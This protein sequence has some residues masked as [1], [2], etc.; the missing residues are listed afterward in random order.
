MFYNFFVNKNYT[1]NNMKKIFLGL[2]SNIGNKEK[3]IK[4]AIKLLSDFV[5]K[6]KVS[7]MYKSKAYGFENQDDFLNAAISGYTDLDLEEL[8]NKIKWIEKKIGRKKRFHWGP[9]EIDID[10]LFYNSMVY[11]DENITVPHPRLHERDF[12]LK[13]LMDLDPKLVHPVLNKSIEDL[14]TQLKDR[15]I[16]G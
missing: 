10:I 8:F 1:I 9:R 15:Y 6:I 13:P 4:E 12:V 7:K 2:G 14:F 5:F 16:I 11:S 3:N